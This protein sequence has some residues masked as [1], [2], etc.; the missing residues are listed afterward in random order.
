MCETIRRVLV[1]VLYLYRMKYLT[2]QEKK[3]GYVC[4]GGKKDWFSLHF[5]D[6]S[7]FLLIQ[8]YLLNSKG[9]T[10]DGRK[11]RDKDC[12]EIS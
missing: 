7:V 3:F 2:L 9:N 12:L 5:N 10:M 11:G 1:T 8:N 4:F 6:I